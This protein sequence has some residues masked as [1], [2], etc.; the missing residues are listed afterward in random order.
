MS[1][2]DLLYGLIAEFGDPDL[3][4]EAATKAYAIGYRNLEAYTPFPV[5]GLSEAI[6]FRHDGVRWITL[7]GGIVGAVSG[8]LLEYYVCVIAY[9]LNIGGRPLV[10]WPAWIPVAFECTILFA[11]FAAVLGMFILN[12]LPQPY[13]PIFNAENFQLATRNRFFLCIEAKDTL[14]NLKDTRDF[15]QQL[16][17]LHVGDVMP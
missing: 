11:A 16:S 10:S 2:T 1:E 14:F 15:L 9:P 8:L 4:K 13:H 7:V 17:P 12:K 3:L 5:D 6:G